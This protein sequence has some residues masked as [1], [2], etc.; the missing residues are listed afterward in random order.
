MVE[1]AKQEQELAEQAERAREEAEL[2]ELLRQQA[3]LDALE[4]EAR[5]LLDDVP[6]PI[7]ADEYNPPA[8]G[9]MDI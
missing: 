5:A 7:P 3:E 6:Q 2:A 8:G 1:L 9:G 4:A